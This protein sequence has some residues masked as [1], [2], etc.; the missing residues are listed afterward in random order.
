MC[1]AASASRLTRTHIVLVG[2]PKR[3]LCRLVPLWPAASRIRG[4]ET[5]GCLWLVICYYP[6][7]TY[8]SWLFAASVTQL[9]LA[10]GGEAAH[11]GPGG[12]AGSS[13]GTGG[14]VGHGGANA[15]GSSSRGGASNAGSSSGGK[16]NGGNANGG[17][18]SGG[19]ASGGNA[20]GG[21]GGALTCCGA[22]PTCPAGEHQVQGCPSQASCHQVTL[23]CS[24]IWCVTDG[25]GGGAGGASARDCNG[26]TCTAMQACI[27][28]RTI[29]GAISLP[30]CPT[31][32][33][34]EG[35]YCQPDFAY[36]CA[37]LKGTCLNQPVSC[38]CAEPPTNHPGVC[39]AGFGS[40]SEPGSEDVPAQLI[41]EQ[42]AP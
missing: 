18:A 9:L 12:T 4:R 32:K 19:N 37:D 20:N 16:A 27:A 13:P 21:S 17:N 35:G 5:C 26:T 22:V 14:Q 28:Y 36:K 24:S 29:G 8:R 40:C 10:C 42:H 38:E 6:R 3:Q 11:P 31:G 2:S 34:V 30:P 15:A 7:M 33:H 23:C 25:G 1:R 41:C 39:P